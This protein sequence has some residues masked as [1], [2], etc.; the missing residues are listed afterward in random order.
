[1]R[2]A[3]IH[4]AFAPT[5]GGVETHLAILGPALAAKGHSVFLLTGQ[6]SGTPARS[7]YSGMTVV[8]TPWLDLNQMSEVRFRRA[9]ESVTRTLHAFLGEVE[10]DVIH[11]HN[12]HYFSPVPLRVIQEWA[13][14]RDVPVV[15]TAHN[16]W[17]DPLFREVGSLASDLDHVIA[18][19]HFIRQ[20]LIRL[21]YPAD[22]ISVVHHGVE[23]QWL[24]AP[25]H[26]T[27]PHQGMQGRPV[28]FHPARMGFG[29]GS[30]IVVEAF[31]EV[32]RV[33]PDAYLMLAGTDKT[34]DWGHSQPGQVRQL[35][36]RVRALGLADSVGVD[37]YPWSL[38]RDLYDASTVV[39]YPSVA[40][41]PF[42][43]VVI[44]AMARGRPVVVSTSGGMPELVEPGV[45]GFIVRPGSVEELAEALVQLLTDGELR[46][47][48]GEAARQR[49]KT[50]FTAA[51]M[52]DNTEHILAQAGLE[53]SRGRGRSFAL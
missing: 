28:I 36:E 17:D 20:D 25:P 9:E 26:P 21:G 49:V 7:Q 52:V 15:L 35:F 14:R 8:R 40:P 12:L 24:S 30:H 45:S 41:E 16:T 53:R 3:E 47:K 34:V 4:W 22:R 31:A 23:S 50:H 5:I 1:M 33:V 29:K 2:I 19:S 43:I 42:G 44:E 38:M 27:Y 48:L 10:P 11:V 51:A 18:V 13:R 46:R 6:P 32:R 37:T 39:V